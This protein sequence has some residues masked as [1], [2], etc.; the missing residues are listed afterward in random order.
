MLGR[1]A[2]VLLGLSLV[3]GSPAF[4]DG[5]ADKKITESALREARDLIAREL[6]GHYDIT[7]L[8]V[9]KV[10]APAGGAQFGQDYGL[11]TVTLKFWTK[12]NGTRH[13]SLNP[14]MFE[15]GAAMCQGWLYLHCGVPAGHVF[16]GILRLLLA[17][18]RDG[19][20]RAVSPR[21]RSR[22]QYALHGYLVL[23]G[24]PPEGYVVF[25][26]RPGR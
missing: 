2:A 21:W 8:E 20:W 22:S 11:A 25:P 1:L 13:P 5:D 24:R 4:A 6:F 14:A 3:Y 15:P 10:D 19:Q 18:D 17:V 9:V 23:N 16:D 12:R 7:T 26:R